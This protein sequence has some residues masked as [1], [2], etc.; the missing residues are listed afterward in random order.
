MRFSS[1]YKVCATEA[2]IQHRGRITTIW[3]WCNKNHAPALRH[4]WNPV[5]SNPFYYLYPFLFVCP[6]VLC[7]YAPVRSY[8]Y[9]TFSPLRSTLLIPVD[10]LSGVHLTH[11]SI[12][13]PVMVLPAKRFPY[14]SVIPPCSLSPPLLPPLRCPPP[15]YLAV[16]PP[17]GHLT[18]IRAGRL[19]QVLYITCKS[20][21]HIRGC[22][23]C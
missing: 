1:G 16:P 20:S 4:L 12:S 2:E 17:S 14:P 23:D 10:W 7:H 22:L 3:D 18:A 11:P 19:V 5:Y 8:H 21:S 9:V 13:F 15:W 6:M